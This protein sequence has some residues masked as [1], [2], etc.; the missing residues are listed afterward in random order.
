MN[1]TMTLIDDGYLS[2]WNETDAARRQA[3]IDR[4]WT[5]DCRYLDPVLQATGREALD[6]M[7]AGV[8]QQFPG[9]RFRRTSG[10][11]GHHDRLRFSWELVGPDG[12]VAVGGVDVAE[13]DAGRLKSVT[14]FFGPMPEDGAGG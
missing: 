10:I 14:G 9:H 2:M 4:I 11:D 7:V 12:T 5:E 13:V 6:G 8:H 1:E 3:T